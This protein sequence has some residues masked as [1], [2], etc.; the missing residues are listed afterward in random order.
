MFNNIS[1]L[2]YCRFL[3][4]AIVA[5]IYNL[6]SLKKIRPEFE[7]NP[8]Q[9]PHLQINIKTDFYY[10]T[11]LG[12]HATQKHPRH[13]FCLL[14]YERLLVQDTSTGIKIL[15]GENIEQADDF[16]CLGSYIA[17]TEYD[18]NIKLGKVWGAL[19]LMNQMWKQ[20]LPDKLKRN[21]YRTSVQSVLVYV[22]L[23]ETLRA[24][25]EKMLDGAYTRILRAA[26]NKP[27]KI[28]QQRNSSI[29]TY[30]PSAN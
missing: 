22:S 25:L 21:F 19:D 1:K 8:K 11:N 4:A 18:V 13:P 24:K 29:A 6:M 12:R 9:L 3:L 7:P 23:T 2:G 10:S 15:T 20:N 30:L 5:K 27:G 26:L 16:K 28:N 14:T 17:S